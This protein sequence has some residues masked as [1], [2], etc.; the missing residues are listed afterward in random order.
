MKELTAILSAYCRQPDKTA[1]LATLVQA[2]G[3]TYRRPG[4]RM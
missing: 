1:A 4:A 2:S 3:S